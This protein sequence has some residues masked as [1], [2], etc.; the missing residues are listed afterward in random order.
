MVGN[1]L[2]DQFHFRRVGE[3]PN[4]TLSFFLVSECDL[5]TVSGMS[6]LITNTIRLSALAVNRIDRPPPEFPDL[7][8]LIDQLFRFFFF[9]FA[10]SSHG[11]PPF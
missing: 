11:H 7:S 2:P 10:S 6:F 4:S 3:I 5:R 8:Q 1:L 9:S